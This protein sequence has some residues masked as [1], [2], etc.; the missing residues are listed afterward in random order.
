M[1]NLQKWLLTLMAAFMLTGIA[2]GCTNANS[3]EETEENQDV[4]DETNEQTEAEEDAG[5]ETNTDDTEE[6]GQ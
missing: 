3:E 2:T 5:D 6:E 1:K 4:E